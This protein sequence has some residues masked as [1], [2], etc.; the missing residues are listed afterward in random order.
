MASWNLSKIEERLSRVVDEFDGKVAK[1]G[2]FPG[3]DY[4]DGTPV[5]YVATIHEYGSPANNIPPRPFMSTTQTER[6][7]EWAKQVGAGAARVSQGRMSADDVLE[8]VGAMA[9]GDIQKTISQITS[10]ALKPATIAARGRKYASGEVTASM[11]KPLV[12]TGLMIS[13]IQ[14]M[15]D[16]SE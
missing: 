16:K 4:P 14:S 5:A 3:A 15:V 2:W 10:P 13:S 9:R 11:E 1:I 12:D 7:S 8:A 6:G